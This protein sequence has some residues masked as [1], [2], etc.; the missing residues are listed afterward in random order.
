MRAPKPL[1]LSA[2]H[3]KRKDDVSLST[4]QKRVRRLG[5]TGPVLL[6]NP[7]WV[8]GHLQWEGYSTHPHFPAVCFGAL[9]IKTN[10]APEP[11]NLRNGCAR[12]CNRRDSF[13]LLEG[14]SHLPSLAG[15]L[16]FH[17]RQGE[18]KN[19]SQFKD[20]RVSG[21]RTAKQILKG[22]HVTLPK[23]IMKPES[24]PLAWTSFRQNSSVLPKCCTVTCTCF[25]I[26]GR[27]PNLGHPAGIKNT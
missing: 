4:I 25:G 1:V 27:T 18:K 10:P 22:R 7:A 16:R 20:P 13:G 3:P 17:G 19:C 11:E 6:K 23:T 2:S 12:R 14:F 5:H 24:V 26:S 8:S 15:C 9:A 21:K